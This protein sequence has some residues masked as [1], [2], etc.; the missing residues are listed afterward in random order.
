MNENKGQENQVLVIVALACSVLGWLLAWVP[1]VNL[2]GLILAVVGLL[3]GIIL[4][5]MKQ[6]RN[7]GEYI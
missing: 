5:L 7:K 3:L 4:I 6:D 1:F 2:F